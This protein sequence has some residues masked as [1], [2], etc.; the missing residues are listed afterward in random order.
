MFTIICLYHPEM[1]IANPRQARGWVS[2]TFPAIPHEIF[3]RNESKKLLSTPSPYV[4]QPDRGGVLISAVG[5]TAAF[6]LREISQSIKDQFL[7]GHPQGQF[8]IRIGVA[9]ISIIPRLQNFALHDFV[10]QNTSSR[11]NLWKEWQVNPD[12]KRITDLAEKLFRE[13]LQNRADLAGVTIP[14]EAIFGDFKAFL[15]RPVLAS[16]GFAQFSVA[17][18]FR[19]NVEFIGPWNFGQLSNR[20]AGRLITVRHPRRS[21]YSAKAPQNQETVS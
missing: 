10:L 2:S 5:E 12:E 4:V 1:L 7:A 18:E 16:S 3:N 11:K 8:S 9:D 20:G 13:R 21:A 15:T 19:A 14:E 6:R 17:L